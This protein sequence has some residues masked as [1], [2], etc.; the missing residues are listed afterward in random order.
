MNESAPLALEVLP[1]PTPGLFLGTFCRGKKYLAARR[2]LAG[3]EARLGLMWSQGPR[4]CQGTTPSGH[5]AAT[6][7]VQGEAT[8]LSKEMG[9]GKARFQRRSL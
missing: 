4:H 9:S 1:R 7:P 6:S 3:L 2:N 8:A 5:Y